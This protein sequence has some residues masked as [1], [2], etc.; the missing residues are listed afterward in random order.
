ML[1]G[2]NR[3]KIQAHILPTIVILGPTASG[4]TALAVNLAKLIEGEIISADSR[5]VYKGMDIGT[6]KDL[7]EYENIP[8][9][10]IDIVE[11]GEK[12]NVARFIFDAKEAEKSIKE[13]GKTPIICGGTGLYIQGFL[14]GIPYSQAPQDEEFRKHSQY[15]TLEELREKI[16]EKTLAFG[17]KLDFKPDLSTHKRALRALEIM[18]WLEK[19]HIPEKKIINNENLF[20]FGL[21]PPLEIRREKITKRLEKRFEEGLIGECKSLLEAGVSHEILQYYGLEY[22]YCSEYLSGT[23]SL[24]ILKE[25]LN[26][27][28]HRFAKRQMTYFRKM[29]KDGIE[30]NWISM[31]SLQEQTQSI[32]EIIS[33]NQ[34]F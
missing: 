24:E 12:Y 19:G 30:I 28:I 16:N 3:L 7:A 6:G 21:Q 33:R 8:Y 22:K 1:E 9:H 32:L 15:F 31:G 26:T 25:K 13:K 23:I 2:K 10:L 27:E 17:S 5:Q 18:E 29:I 4:K 34:R 20:V 14:Q 11:A